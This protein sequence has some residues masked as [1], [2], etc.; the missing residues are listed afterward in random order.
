M[1]LNYSYLL[2]RDKIPNPIDDIIDAIFACV[3]KKS[4]VESKI[5]K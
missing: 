1:L 4:E 2:D 5:L 3:V